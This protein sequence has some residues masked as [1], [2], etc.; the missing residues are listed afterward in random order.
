MNL[1]QQDALQLAETLQRA[2]SSLEGLKAVNPWSV[3]DTPRARSVQMLVEAVDPGFAMKLK[4]AAGHESATPSLAYVAAQAAGIAPEAMQGEA[5]QDYARFNPIDPEKAA[6][7]E[8]NILA[9]LDAMTE[10]SQR[11]REGDQ[12]YEQR[13]EREQAK[14]KAEADRLAEGRQLDARIRAKQQQIQNLGR[15]A[16]GNVIAPNS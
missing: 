13:I 15:I 11:R 12:A 7:E 1:D 8:A 16:A 2:G 5:A 10:A 6:E 9:K 14:A 4:Q 3:S